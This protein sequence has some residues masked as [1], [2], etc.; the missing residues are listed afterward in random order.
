MAQW[1]ICFLGLSVTKYDTLSM[2]SNSKRK[3][4]WLLAPEGL[5]G[6]LCDTRDDAIGRRES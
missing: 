1:R 6:L 3:Y 2:E 4:G 5:F